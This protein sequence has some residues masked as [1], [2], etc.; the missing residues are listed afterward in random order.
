MMRKVKEKCLKI[1]SL[2]AKKQSKSILIKPWCVVGEVGVT[3]ITIELGHPDTLNTRLW[4]LENVYVSQAY[5][6]FGNRSAL[7]ANISSMPRN[8]RILGRVVK[9]SRHLK[10][11][12]TFLRVITTIYSTATATYHL[13][14]AWIQAWNHIVI[15]KTRVFQFDT[16]KK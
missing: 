15:K 10:H 5:T 7:A 8:I 2:L 14:C 16:F 1:P 4:K 9:I 12:T 3:V 13:R 6:F 11:K